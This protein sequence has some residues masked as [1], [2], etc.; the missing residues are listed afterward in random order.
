[1]K[2]SLIVALLVTRFLVAAQ[3]RTNSAAASVSTNVV[4]WPTLNY[5]NFMVD[6]PD[7]IKRRQLWNYF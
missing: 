1:M 5:T 7:Q 2:L 6:A 4:L 3:G